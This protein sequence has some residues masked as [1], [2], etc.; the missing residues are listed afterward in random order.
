MN[1]SVA[2]NILAL[3]LGTHTGVAQGSFLT[4][5]KA[6]TWTL[7]T[8]KEIRGWNC[9]GLLRRLDP[10]IRRF[11]SKVGEAQLSADLLVFED[12]QF[13]SS[14]FQTQLWSSFRGAL[15][16]VAICPV[17]CVPV[18]TLKKF[19]TGSGAADKADMSAAL[20]HKF[21]QTKNNGWDD[22]AIDAIWLWLWAQNTI[23]KARI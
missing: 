9:Q 1:E 11:A 19:A 15:W 6:G 12:V 13:S 8:P 16:T 10:R 21:P 20:Y 18:G 23:A 4:G 22:N 2:M 14:T 7:A 17:A 5:F 3:D